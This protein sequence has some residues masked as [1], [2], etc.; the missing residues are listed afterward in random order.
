MTTTTQEFAALVAP[1]VQD[2]QIDLLRAALTYGKAE[3]PGL[4][5]E[6]YLGRVVGIADRVRQQLGARLEPGAVFPILNRVLFEVEGFR[7]NRDDYYDP[8]NSYLNEVLDRKTGIPIT[9]SVVY[10]EVARRVG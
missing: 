9:L 3:Y 1:D 10:M 7:G 2:E 4:D 5:I 8:R 6:H